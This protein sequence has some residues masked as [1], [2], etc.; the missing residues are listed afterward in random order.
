MQ[1]TGLIRVVGIST[2][3][4]FVVLAFATRIVATAVVSTVIARVAFVTSSSS[5][6]VVATAVVSLEIV[7]SSGKRLERLLKFGLESF[8]FIGDRFNRFDPSGVDSNF[9]VELLRG[10]RLELRTF[11]VYEGFPFVG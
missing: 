10:H 9:G 5:F 4:I 3:P 7:K 11:G 2:S 6:A 8:D 1:F